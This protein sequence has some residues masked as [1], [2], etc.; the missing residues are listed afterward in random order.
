MKKLIAMLIVAAMLFGMAACKDKNNGGNNNPSQPPSPTS[1]GINTP[2]QPAISTPD[3]IITGGGVDGLYTTVMDSYPRDETREQKLNN[4]ANYI[5]EMNGYYNFESS[6]EFSVVDIRSL[7]LGYAGDEGSVSRWIELY[8]VTAVYY[9][10]D[11]TKVK[12][13]YEKQPDGGII[14][15]W[16]EDEAK[17][18][19][20]VYQ[21]DESVSS[22][23]AMAQRSRTILTGYYSEAD[24]DAI[25]EQYAYAGMPDKYYS[26]AYMGIE[27][28]DEEFAKIDEY[29]PDMFDPYKPYDKEC[30]LFFDGSQ[31]PHGPG[32]KDSFDDIPDYVPQLRSQELADGGYAEYDAWYNVL[33]PGIHSLS[34]FVSQQGTMQSQSVNV[35]REDAYTPRGLRVGDSAER[36]EQLYPEM[37]HGPVPW[38]EDE[39]GDFY[40]LNKDEENHFGA[41]LV[42]KMVNNKVAEIWCYSVIM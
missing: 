11:L 18:Y 27:Q 26:T 32:L 6:T 21:K 7:D 12:C 41:T 30:V 14:P 1:S 36:V 24:C 31:I 25:H 39:P 20:A 2:T 35:T 42:F 38:Y 23:G 40:W 22:G 33:Y 29:S 3:A 9:P 13:K 8:E 28:G 5:A 4:W 34:Y 19:F 10:P 37:Q 17:K 15:I 16:G